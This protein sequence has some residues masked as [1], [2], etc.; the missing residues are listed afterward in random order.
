MNYNIKIDLT[1]INSA[2]LVNIKG[3]TAT[4]QCIVIP[5]EDAGLFVGE[6][7]VYL[8]LQAIELKEQKFE[9]T[10]MVK[11][12]VRSEAYKA[13]TEDERKQIPIIGGMKAR[14]FQQ[15]Q[16]R[17]ASGTAEFSGNDDDLPF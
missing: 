14:E 9:Q 10:H 4:K 1:K 17:Q 13:M 3:K 15:A 5:V 8:N 11:M 7:G 2:A 16:Q 6:K 12:D